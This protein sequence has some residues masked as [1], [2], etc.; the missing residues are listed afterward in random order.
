M[1]RKVPMVTVDGN[2]NIT[3][4]G[5]SSFKVYVDGKPNV[6]MSS[7]PSA[8][9]KNM[10]A[11]AVKNIEVITNPGVKYDAEGVGGVLNLVMDKT[12]GQAAADVSGYNGTIRGMATTR[13]YRRLS[14]WA[15]SRSGK[16]VSA[17][18]PCWRRRCADSLRCH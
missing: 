15:M 3:V 9:F 13:G 14:C 10:P 2:D 5:S 6:M 1:L 18:A 4:N 16:R 8:I 17:S 12:T 11:S 7:N